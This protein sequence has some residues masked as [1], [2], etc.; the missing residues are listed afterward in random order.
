MKKEKYLIVS[1][2]LVALL[3]RI[4]WVITYPTE[5]ISDFIGYH[6]IA[7]SLLENSFYGVDSPSCYRPPGYPFLLFLIYKFINLNIST[8]IIVNILLEVVSCYLV[9][10]LALLVFNRRVALIALIIFVFN[11]VSI[12]FCSLLASEHLFITI[13]LLLLIC[14]IKYMQNDKLVFLILSGFLWGIGT[15]VRAQ[16]LIYPIPIFLTFLFVE[17]K[18]KEILK[19]L[20]IYFIMFCLCILPWTIRNYIQFKRFILVS[21]NSGIVLYVGNNPKTYKWDNSVIKIADVKNKSNEEADKIYKTLAIKNI[22]SRPFW[23]FSRGFLKV[24]LLLESPTYPLFWINKG[25]NKKYD[26]SYYYPIVIWYFRLLLL[27]SCSSL[28]I[29]KKINNFH[30]LIFLTVFFW[31]LVAFIFWAQSRYNYPIEPI[32]SVYAGYSLSYRFFR[33]EKENINRERLS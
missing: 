19:F 22:K 5:Q 20:I 26:F 6:K 18:Y 13:F 14:L 29:I 25:A 1:L 31:W 2:L 30:K 4:L 9:Y 10:L 17:N 33:N 16:L 24:N 21:C 15:L 8:A 32:M 12:T 7:L 11:P 3:I 27:L 23:Y 28:I